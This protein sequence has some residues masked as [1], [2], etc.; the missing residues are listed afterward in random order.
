MH[1]L[2]YNLYSFWKQPWHKQENCLGSALW[3]MKGEIRQSE[4][5]R[6]DVQENNGFKWSGFTS[7]HITSNNGGSVWMI[8]L[9]EGW[10]SECQWAALIN[11]K[12]G[13][14]FISNRVTLSV[15]AVEWTE[16]LIRAPSKCCWRIYLAKSFDRKWSLEMTGMCLPRIKDEQP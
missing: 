10:K 12:P 1:N 11:H 2:V 9:M 4:M 6:H 13:C 15:S 16:K 3:T 5:I 8:C 14:L 7:G